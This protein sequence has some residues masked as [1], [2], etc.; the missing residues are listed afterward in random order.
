MATKERDGEVSVGSECTPKSAE[1]NAKETILVKCRGACRSAM[2][3]RVVM[4]ERSSYKCAACLEMLYPLPGHMLSHPI[5]SHRF[6]SPEPTQLY[7]TSHNNNSTA[8]T[9]RSVLV[10]LYIGGVGTYHES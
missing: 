4:D 8:H 5:I 1:E 6:L 2:N 9:S 3:I 10:V 7:I